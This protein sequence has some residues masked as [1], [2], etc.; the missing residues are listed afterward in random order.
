VLRVALSYLVIAWLVLQVGDVLLDPLGAPAWAMRLLIVLAAIGFPVSLIMAWF[1]E[2]TPSGIEVDHLPETAKRPTVRGVRHYADIV[3][4]VGLLLV[5]AFLLVRQQDLFPDAAETPVV[6]ILPFE[7]L[8]SSADNHFGDGFADTLIHKL[9]MLDQMVVLASSSTFEFRANAFDLSE[10]AAKLGASVLLQGSLRRA[11]GLLRLDAQLVDGASGQ[12]LWSGRFRRPVDDVFRVQ[13]EIANAIATTIGVEMIPSQVER[14]ARPPTSS[15]AAYDT[16]LRASREALESRDVEQFPQALQFL[17][18][19]IELDPEFALAHATL[20]EAMHL[21]ASLRQWDTSWSDFAD[22]ARAA[23]ARAQELDPELGEGY[24]AEAFV[25][26]WELDEGIADHSKDHIIA[27]TEKALQ[28]SPNNPRALKM[29]FALLDDPER[30]LELITRAARIDPRSGIIR[31]NV[32]EWYIEA[33]EFDQ[34]EHWFMRA[35]RARDPYFR[36]GY[37][38]LVEMNVWDAVR[39]D[40]AA[41][42]GR[43]FEAAHPGDWASRIAYA[44]SLMELGAWKELDELLKRTQARADAGDPYIAW[45][46]TYLAQW[47]AYVQGDTDK[48][49]D[50]AERYVRENLLPSPGWP[51]VSNL[52]GPLLRTFDLLALMDLS[53]GNA[54][55]AL[56]RYTRAHLNLENLRWSGLDGPAISQAVMFAV[57]HRH[58]G[59]QDEAERQLRELLSRLAEEPVRGF[60]G[61]GFAEF[62]I[63]AFLGET[64][65]AIEALRAVVDKGWLPG[66]WGLGFGAFD[67]NYAAVLADPRYERLHQ[68][69]IDR[70]AEQ[71]ESFRASPNLPEELLLESGLA[72][73]FAAR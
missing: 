70:V 24:L 57:L 42:W 28:L 36:I 62:T 64:D 55:A 51:D 31:V 40:R 30:R 15:M 44:R 67:D 11:G 14:I 18:D 65:A 43:A 60:G 48:A 27:L 35:A 3:I 50:L 34:A 17:H 69:I 23:A 21:A 1:L 37:K 71:R 26:G 39:L 5:V 38:M 46:Y 25:A 66:W 4:I 54:Q 16:F 22:E 33:G 52:Q 72:T 47:L 32:A 53:R 56:D 9:G 45:T 73:P 59:R 6:A 61:N 63:Y 58:T 13:D 12:Q 7:E 19:A 8:D 41:R 2:V 29:L 10:I 20:V 49:L 68:E